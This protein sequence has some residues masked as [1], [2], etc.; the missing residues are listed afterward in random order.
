MNIEG[1]EILNKTE[2]IEAA[3]PSWATWTMI[4]GSLLFVLGGFLFSIIDDD[5][6]L[7]FGIVVALLLVLVMSIIGFM[8]EGE[9][10]T[11]R[12]RYEVLMSDDVNFKEVY[13]KYKLIETRG[14]IF[15]FEDKE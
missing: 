6:W 15:V 13:E 14:E 10:H 3:F 11:G 8:C 12:Y 4:I 7:A 5:A 9:V 2:I 1:I